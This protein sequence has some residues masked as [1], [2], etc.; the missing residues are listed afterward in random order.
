M[1]DVASICVGGGV[2]GLITF[3]VDCK[4]KMML[5][6]AWCCMDDMWGSGGGGGG[7]IT[8]IVDCKQK[9]VLFCGWSCAF[10]KRK[11]W[12]AM[13]CCHKTFSFVRSRHNE[14]SWRE[15]SFVVPD[16]NCHLWKTLKTQ[17]FLTFHVPNARLW[18][19]VLPCLSLCV[20]T[21]YMSIYW[22]A[23]MLTWFHNVTVH[24]SKCVS[25]KRVAL[26]C[27]DVC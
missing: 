21:R 22:V 9:M 7:L 27:R 19:Y 15:K 6:C 4:Q 23:D 11:F 18:R 3:V 24:F 20:V 16:A 10:H 17:C 25:N 1:D 5:S 26:Q 2:G 13:L 14:C 8:F 12:H